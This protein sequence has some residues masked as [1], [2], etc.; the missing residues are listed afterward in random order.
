MDKQIRKQIH[1]TPGSSYPDK[2]WVWIDGRSGVCFDRYEYQPVKREFTDD[3][4]RES[5]IR[6]WAL[7]DAEEVAYRML[8]AKYP[9][10]FVGVGFL[11][12]RAR[13]VADNGLSGYY[14]YALSKRRKA[15]KYQI[16]E[17]IKL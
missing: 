8:E 7:R 4:L 1:Y 14:A 6:Y 9:D 2:V 17:A 3:E 13:D 10:Q 11:P 15:G 5:A 16:V 12:A